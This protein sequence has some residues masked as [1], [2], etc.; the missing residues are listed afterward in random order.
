MMLRKV[1]FIIISIY[2]A[3]GT[4][5]VLKEHPI[6]YLSNPYNSTL[7]WDN[8]IVSIYSRQRDT[9]VEEIIPYLRPPC[10]FV[11]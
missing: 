6:H 4:S 3:H 2:K 1:G 7:R 8:T 10:E 9:E 11:V 5:Q